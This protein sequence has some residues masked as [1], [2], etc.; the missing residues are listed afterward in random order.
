MKIQQ[1][2]VAPLNG[3]TTAG[4]VSNSSTAPTSSAK[5]GSPDGATKAGATNKSASLKA[6]ELAI[7][8]SPSFNEA[9]VN[10]IKDSIKAGTFNVNAVKVA[11]NLAE[12]AAAFIK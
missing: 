2:P 10:A 3:L 11:N 12:S 4:A 1:P 5:I 6:I 7:A 8:A 9:K